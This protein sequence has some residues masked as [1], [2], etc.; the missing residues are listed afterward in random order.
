M[1]CECEYR[2]AWPAGIT[3][4]WSSSV[5]PLA[6]ADLILACGTVAPSR[7]SPANTKLVDEY[8]PN[9]KGRCKAARLQKGS[10]HGVYMVHSPGL[11][12]KGG[13][14]LELNCWVMHV[15]HSSGECTLMPGHRAWR[16]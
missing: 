15:T 7:T 16:M 11:H 9:K 1:N 8:L 4:V 2:A 14:A 5:Q 3:G 6:P 10:A 13:F 12:A